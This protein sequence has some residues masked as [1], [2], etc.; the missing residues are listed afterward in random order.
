MKNTNVPIYLSTYLVEIQHFKWTK[1]QIETIPNFLWFK[2]IWKVDQKVWTRSKV[3]V[4]MREYSDWNDWKGEG[5]WWWSISKMVQFRLGFYDL[6]FLNRHSSQGCILAKLKKNIFAYSFVSEPYMEKAHV[7][8]C[9]PFCGMRR[10]FTQFCPSLPL[11]LGVFTQFCPSPPQ[12]L[13]FC[14]WSDH[15]V[16]SM[17]VQNIPLTLIWF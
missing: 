17:Y 8:A 5:G 10:V 11:F 1:L 12:K 2:Q 4:G 14:R 7:A 15:R 9:G 3:Y 16:F 13:D 6:T